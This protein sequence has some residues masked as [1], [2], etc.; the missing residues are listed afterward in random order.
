MVCA[1]DIDRESFD[2][3]L[4]IKEPHN[5]NVVKDMVRTN[6]MCFYV[7][8][9]EKMVTVHGFETYPEMNYLNA[10]S[11][12]EHDSKPGFDKVPLNHEQMEIQ[13]I[14]CCRH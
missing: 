10:M 14:R 7:N 9:I 1:Q 8:F 5:V 4:I 12:H 6:W 13:Y 2:L 3:S 11:F